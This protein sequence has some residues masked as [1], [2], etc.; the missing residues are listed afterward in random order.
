MPRE[1]DFMDAADGVTRMQG[2]YQLL[3]SD[4]ANGLL[5]RV[6]YKCV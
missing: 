3:A 1:H 6:Q 5:D 4:I 2:T